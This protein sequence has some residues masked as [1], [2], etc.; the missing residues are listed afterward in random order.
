MAFHMKKK[1]HPEY[2][3]VVAT[4][5]CGAQF[6]VGSTKQE[7]RV[8]LCSQCHPVFTGKHKIVDTEGRVDR[9]RRRFKIA[10]TA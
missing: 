2:Y 4:C 10:K 5:A 8:D 1:L 9:F 7:I 6:M 3:S